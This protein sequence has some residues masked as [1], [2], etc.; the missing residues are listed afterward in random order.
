MSLR[1]LTIACHALLVL[2]LM[3]AVLGAGYTAPRAG[4]AFVLVAPLLGMLP[5]LLRES[6]SAERWLAVLLVP[7]LGIASVEVVANAGSATF[8][9]IALLASA[10][11]LGLLL[12][13]IGRAHRPLRD[14]RGR[15]GS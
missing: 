2:A 8:M 6:R 3:A 15:T 1:T 5:A 14:G 7:Y 13:V 11:E 12:A 10:L 9:N 4:L